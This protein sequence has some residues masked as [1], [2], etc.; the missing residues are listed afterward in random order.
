MRNRRHP[1]IDALIVSLCVEM[2]RRLLTRLTL[3]ILKLTELRLPL[4]LR[5][6]F[7]PAIGIIL[8]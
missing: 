8:S 1:Y 5:I 7:A 6:N 3:S 4:Q 2:L